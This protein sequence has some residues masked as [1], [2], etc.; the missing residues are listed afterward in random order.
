MAKSREA[1]QKRIEEM[2][3]GHK[4]DINVVQTK[5]GEVYRDTLN[6]ALDIKS[7]YF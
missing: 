6:A 3:L 4:N 2:N 5:L 1:L 7:K